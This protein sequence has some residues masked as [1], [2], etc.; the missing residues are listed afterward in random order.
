MLANKGPKSFISGANVR[1][2][3]VLRTV[4]RKPISGLKETSDTLL[5]ENIDFSKEKPLAGIN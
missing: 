5:V 3:E 4:N 2:G 1:L